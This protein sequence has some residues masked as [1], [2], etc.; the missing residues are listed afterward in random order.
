MRQA[1]I[2]RTVV[3]VCKHQLFQLSLDFAPSHSFSLR[4]PIFMLASSNCV[5]DLLQHHSHIDVNVLTNG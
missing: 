2:H 4:V 3:G 1:C 5:H